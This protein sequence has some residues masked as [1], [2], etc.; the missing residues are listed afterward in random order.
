[1]FCIF[2]SIAYIQ[3]SLPP[4]RQWHEQQESAMKKAFTLIELLVVISIISLLISILLPA[5]SKAR[6]A[7]RTIVCGNNLKQ[8]GISFHLYINDY[9]GYLPTGLG[10][11]SGVRKKILW[12]DLLGMGYDGRRL[13]EDEQLADGLVVGTYSGRGS[14]IYHCEENHVALNDS[15]S[16]SGTRYY[17]RSYG[18]NNQEISTNG[19][20]FNLSEILKGHEKYILL[21]EDNVSGNAQGREAYWNLKENSYDNPAQREYR[22]E[23]HGGSGSCLML[24]GHVSLMKWLDTRRTYAK[25]YWRRQ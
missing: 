24:D 12:D 7:A 16:S 3:P 8:L 17:A 11:A 22:F 14:K 6:S 10:A 19:Q 13:T 9:K 15:Q 23:V 4:A 25:S 1:M 2:I 21:G 5:L 18:Y 20:S